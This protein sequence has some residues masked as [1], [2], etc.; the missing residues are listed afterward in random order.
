LADPLPGVLPHGEGATAT[1]V[2]QTPAR[3]RLTVI[4][5]YVALT[6]PRI[7]ELLLVTTVPPMFLA[8]GGVPDL[9]LVVAVLVG[10][11]MTAG[12]ANVFNMVR[13][14]DIDAVMVRTRR[15]PIPAGTVS[16]RQAL[17]F[18]S[19]LGAG[20]VAWLEWTAGGL[21]AALAAGAM[22]FYA[23]VYSCWLKRSTVHNIV[24]GG[25]AGAAPCL[26]GWAAVTGTLDPAAWVL[27][28]VVFL[29]TPPHFWALA[30]VH[31]RDYSS[32]EVPMLPSVLGS[33][34]AA[35]RSLRYAAMTVV[36]SLALPLTDD[37]VGLLYVVTAALLGGILL[38]QAW[39][40][41]R[42]PSPKQARRLFGY[43][44][45]YLAAL[46]TAVALD[47]VLRWPFT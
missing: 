30:I 14:R 33:A 17:V 43:S 21:A 25:A 9:W 18:G 38:H 3:T 12:A 6:K 7:I 44:I 5:A 31:E 37:G 26:I 10:G 24:I 16:V 13:D 4:A 19:V 40:V 29:W 41:R 28:A 20:G 47:Q 23:V 34:E 15:R 39:K 27:F 42:W 1:T 11:T 22:V 32:A 36:V 8:A 46:F 45:T 35:R 2:V